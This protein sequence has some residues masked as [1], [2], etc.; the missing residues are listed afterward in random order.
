L[1]RREELSLLE[2]AVAR[3]SDGFGSLA[4]VGGEGGIGRSRLVSELAGRAERDV[5]AVV[6]GECPPLGDGEL[7]DAPLLA[8]LRT[9]EDERSS[10]QA[11]GPA[12]LGLGRTATAGEN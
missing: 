11:D 12:G 6:I 9:L 2:G 8:A 7:P 5:A 1:S 4:L 3:A 10:V